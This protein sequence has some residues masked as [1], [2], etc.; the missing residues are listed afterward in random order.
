MASGTT[1]FPVVQ[2][3]PNPAP[4]DIRPTDHSAL[5]FL[6]HLVTAPASQPY[7]QWKRVISAP[8][9]EVPPPPPDNQLLHRF[10]RTFQTVGQ[11]WPA[12]WPRFVGTAE[13][14]LQPPPPNHDALHR[15]R[16]TF[17]TV[18]QPAWTLYARRGLLEEADPFTPAPD[19]SALFRLRGAQPKAVQPWWM[20]A[21]DA[22][23]L[24]DEPLP[25]AP[26]SQG[27]FRFRAPAPPA[28]VFQ[29]VMR[30]PR[31]V[32]SAEEEPQPKPV[33][34]QR[35]FLLLGP[36]IIRVKATAP[37]VYGNVYRNIGDVFDIIAGDFSDASVDYLAGKAGGP[38]FGWMVRV[39]P[40]TPQFNFVEYTGQAAPWLT[41][42]T[43]QRTAF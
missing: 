18:G 5:M 43:D 40:T 8:D 23:R 41:Q 27:L 42:A 35:L 2:Y 13:P 25:A 1:L 29:P 6:R 36:G 28:A 3:V 21:R 38:Q 33:D 12:M 34:Q 26:D 24:D 22:R 14:E 37:G 39:L 15:Y 11:P 9:D 30:F 4:E 7:W 10:R 31:F 19:P 20:W 17:Q 32:G 16:F